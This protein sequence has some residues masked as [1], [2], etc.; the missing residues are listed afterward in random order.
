[1]PPLEGSIY[2]MS[3]ACVAS[4]LHFP[5]EDTMQGTALKVIEMHGRFQV[6]VLAVGGCLKALFLCDIVA[7]LTLRP[8]IWAGSEGKCEK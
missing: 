3:H 5:E 6:Y 8:D 2:L 1:M 7:V 4:L